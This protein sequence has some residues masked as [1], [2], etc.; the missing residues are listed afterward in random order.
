[1]NDRNKTDNQAF[2]QQT[3][4]LLDDSTEALDAATLSR[5]NQAR[6]KALQHTGGRRLPNLQFSPWA[7]ATLI[8]GFAVVAIAVVLW[9]AV[10]QQ[11]DQQQQYR[12]ANQL[13]DM[14]IL[15]SET[16]LELLDELEFISWLVDEELEENGGGAHAGQNAG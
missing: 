4:Q 13:E 11:L 1:M 9:T 3:R 10:P 2:L 8:A 7:S 12:L 6:Q 5:L 16:E 15:M 14:D